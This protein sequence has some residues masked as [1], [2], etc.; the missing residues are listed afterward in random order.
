MYKD[1]FLMYTGYDFI[2]QSVIHDRSKK[3]AE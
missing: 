2:V 3:K 1:V